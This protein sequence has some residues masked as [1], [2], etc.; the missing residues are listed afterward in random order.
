MLELYLHS[1]IR[2]QGIELNSLN[3]GTTYFTGVFKLFADSSRRERVRSGR[4]RHK[5]K[6]NRDIGKG[7]DKARKMRTKQGE[8]ETA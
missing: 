5:E 2:L 3:T 8:K 7:R 1:P 6:E 4:T